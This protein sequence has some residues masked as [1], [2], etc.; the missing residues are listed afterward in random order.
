MPSERGSWTQAQVSGLAAKL[1][2][3]MD[4]LPEDEQR[5][6]A[7]ILQQA[8]EGAKGSEVTGYGA[9]SS[10]TA[11]VTI[12]NPVPDGPPLEGETEPTRRRIPVS[13]P[14]LRGW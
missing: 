4:G 6:L 10:L 5:I 7:A 12:Y 14:L 9:P 11:H 1:Q 8:A 3:F 2:Q 13:I